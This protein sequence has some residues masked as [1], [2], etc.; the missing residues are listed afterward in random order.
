MASPVGEDAWLAYIQENARTACDLEQHVNVVELYKRAANDEPGSLTLLLAYCNYFQYLW[1]SSNSSD[2]GW[3]EEEQMLGREVFSLGAALDLWQQ[4]YE[5]I[6]YRLSDSHEF[7]NR[8]ISLEMEQFVASQTPE[9]LRRITEMYSHRLATPHLCWDET[10]QA[11]SSFLSQY[12]QPEW[13][14]TMQEVTTSAQLTKRAILVRD[15]FELKLK[16]A[17]RN[18]DIEAQK[19][20]LR[21]Y[22]D[23]EVRGI[24]RRQAD[25]ELTAKLCAGLFD[26][27]L[28]GLFATDEAVWLD[29]I[30][31][32]SSSTVDFQNSA[33]RL[34]DAS[35]RS[36]L[37]CPWSG[38]LWSRYILSAEENN[39][40][41]AE[42]QALKDAATS[43]TLLYKNGM[44]S[45]IE[46]YCAWCA[47]LKRTAL[48]PAAS[49]EAADVA[50]DGLRAAVEDVKV[51]GKRL[52]GKEF[53]GDPKYRLE[54]LYIQYLTEKKGAI[55]D[56]RAHYDFWLNYYLWEMR[57]YSYGQHQKRL[58]LPHDGLH[59]PTAATAV[60]YSAANR[61]TI[62]WP[63][64]ILEVYQQHCN[65]YELPA[66][67]RQ[68]DD[69]VNQTQKVLA[70]R[71]KK[72]EEQ[73][74]AQ[75]A[76][77]YE[78][79]AQAQTETLAH[80]QVEEEQ[81]NEQPI[82]D[83]NA[84]P[85]GPKRKRE[86]PIDS[87]EDLTENA[88]KR[89]RN[90]EEPPNASDQTPK[91][92]REHSTIIVTNLPS[93]ATQTA[94]R[95]YFKQYGHINNITAFVKEEANPS[96][97]ALIEFSSTE[98]AQ[99]ALLKNA[100]YF[101]ESQISVQPGHDLTVYVANYPPAADDNFVRDLFKD[102]GDILSIRWPSLKINT[103]RR[104]CYV[105]FRDRST[106]A[107]AVA[108]DGK[109][110]DGKYRLLAK[111]SDPSRK[112]DREGALAEGREVHI[113]DLDSSATEAELRAVFG[114]FGTVKRVNIPLNMAG[115]N[116]GFAFLDFASRDQAEKA[117]KEL[118][119]TKFKSQILRVE[120]SKENKV[121]PSAKTDFQR[122]SA[123]P[124]PSSLKEDAEGD[125]PTNN[126]EGSSKPSSSEIASRTIAL[127]GLPD[128]VNDARVKALVEPLGAIVKLVHQPGHGGAIIEFADAATAGKAALQLDSM[129]YEGH[130]LR[131]GPPDELRQN[132]PVGTTLQPS[133]PRGLMAPPQAIR[134]PVGRSGSKRGLG[135]ATRPP[136]AAATNSA[137]KAGGPKSNA[138]FKAMFLSGR[139][140]EK[141]A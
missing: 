24:K 68:A 84:S 88:S 17:Q 30:V 65:N 135:F 45:M 105:S 53:Q 49:D 46:M 113:S 39:L 11:F 18:G 93:D 76:A 114:K 15:P 98:E 48:E 104:F 1:Q 8:W 16:Q 120:V 126:A 99:S 87:Q 102:C 41:F 85:H 138:D 58:S 128:T 133:R 127:M 31:F 26:R 72:Q 64:R 111:Y 90:G 94:V 80:V 52:Y 23:W 71:R 82:T 81:E 92:D 119:N 110:L 20:Q 47:F 100:K 69:F 14:R 73:Q 83:V 95:K 130:R 13:E 25:A 59:I 60:L 107:K 61:K 5:A 112:K 122:T 75:Y 89:R 6:Q 106:S 44:E 118:N 131:T 108:K 21:E 132:K 38:R 33:D 7:W 141:E 22:L 19:N 63:E 96:T 117:V 109:L 43:D 74:A 124:A 115:K 2:A 3:S 139:Q 91:R 12:N 67:V 134:R 36:V 77:Y 79:Q 55:E 78:S 27:A 4:S 70:Y 37:H 40:P 140:G 125:K 42:I 97:T 66:S 50:E 86:S 34:L 51:T 54:R 129:E 121:K 56:A 62:D 136:A 137:D 101:G 57:V 28:T 116:R 9:G 35:R 29:Y 103:H 32:L 123:S 10:S